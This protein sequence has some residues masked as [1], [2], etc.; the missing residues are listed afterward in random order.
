MCTLLQIQGTTT[1]QEFLGEI[2]KDEFDFRFNCGYT[3]P[4]TSLD[5]SDKEEFIQAIWLHHVFFLPH[6][7]LEQLHKGFRDTLQVVILPC[8]DGELLH[9]VLASTRAFEPTSRIRLLL[10]I[11]MRDLIIG[12]KRSPS[13]STGLS[14]SVNVKQKVSREF[15][16]KS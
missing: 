11:L 14:M 15:F 8:V 12:P 4:T 13:C 9:A 2:Q 1:K 3:K 10:A 7:E 16:K 6:A 5:I